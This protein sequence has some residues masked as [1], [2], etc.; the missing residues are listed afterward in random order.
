MGTTESVGVTRLENP[1][2]RVEARTGGTDA[3]LTLGFQGVD[4]PSDREEIAIDGF[5]GYPDD[6]LSGYPRLTESSSEGLR[7]TT[8]WESVKVELR[9]SLLP[10]AP[11]LRLSFAFHNDGPIL[12]R[13]AFGLCFHLQGDGL[14]WRAPAGDGLRS[15]PFPARPERRYLRPFRPWCGWEGGGRRATLL[16]PAGVI[17]AVEVRRDPSGGASLSPLAYVLGLSPGCVAD[18]DGL[19]SMGAADAS[20]PEELLERF[21]PVLRAGYRRAEPD[22][23]RETEA[24]RRQLGS[25][26][27]DAAPR[28]ALAEY[29]ERMARMAGGRNGRMALI[30][31]LGRS[32]ASFEDV[33]LSLE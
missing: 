3:L 32:E 33:L 25:A 16:F 8:V 29:G 4:S 17:D 22:E 14:R 13:P 5:L 20:S 21:A 6:R 10:D 11:A 27:P 1:F 23:I 15:G 30:R 28:P 19:L 26:S 18:F 31:R 9:F 7:L 2:L 12:V 24:V